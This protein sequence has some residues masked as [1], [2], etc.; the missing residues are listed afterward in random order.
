MGRRFVQSSTT[1]QEGSYPGLATVAMHVGRLNSSWCKGLW[2][3][4]SLWRE[5]GHMGREGF[6]LGSSPQDSKM[7]LKATE[8]WWIC[9]S[10]V[11]RHQK[12]SWKTYFLQ[13]LQTDLYITV[14]SP[15][16]I[17]LQFLVQLHN[18][19]LSVLPTDVYRITAQERVRSDNAA[20]ACPCGEDGSWLSQLFCHCF[21][22][23]H[24]ARQK[25]FCSYQGRSSRIILIHLTWF[26]SC[27]AVERRMH[28][29]CAITFACAWF[30]M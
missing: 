14:P 22:W 9:W 23:G 10:Q 30:A 3:L 6:K 26:D 8:M 24:W 1:S 16:D 13:I 2:Y 19:A 15:F 7:S 11:T 25:C 27:L 29:P 20:R 5:R 4:R 17:P 12:M 28:V 21:M 18:I